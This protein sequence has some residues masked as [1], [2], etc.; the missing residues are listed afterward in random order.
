MIDAL[1][2]FGSPVSRATV[3]LALLEHPVT[4]PNSMAINATAPHALIPTSHMMHDQ[5]RSARTE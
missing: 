2:A 1:A 4:A 3:R 5:G